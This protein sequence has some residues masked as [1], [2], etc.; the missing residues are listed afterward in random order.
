MKI[1]PNSLLTKILFVILC[2]SLTSC[3]QTKLAYGFLDNWIRWQVN[4]Y[5]DLNKDQSKVLKSA[6][7]DFH[8]W[9]RENEL[10]RYSS[11]IEETISQLD[12][13][14]INTGDVESVLDQVQQ[15][16]DT[17]AQ[18][19]QKPTIS[20]VSTLSEEQVQNILAT[21]EE[22]EKDNLKDIEETTFEER[23]EKRIKGA[24][25]FFAKYLGKLNDEQKQIIA[26]SYNLGKSTHPYGTERNRKWRQEFKSALSSDL[27]QPE[28]EQQLTTLLFKYPEHLNEEHQ[29]ISEHN[30]QITYD[31]IVQLHKTLTKKQ[32]RK[33]FS[34]LRKYQTD[35]LDLAGIDAKEKVLKAGI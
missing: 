18:Q 32:K 17:S 6:S 5:V 9:H 13:S 30:Q 26:D 22:Q 3:S 16:W 35:F 19:L 4:D 20:I 1:T 11:F 10:V 15:L 29:K 14:E 24:Q 27:S 7:K 25:K 23:Q 31:M 12:Q 2:L 21:L 28:N 8:R 33:L 34:K